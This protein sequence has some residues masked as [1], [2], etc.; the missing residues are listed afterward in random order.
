[1]LAV[2]AGMASWLYVIGPQARLTSPVLMKIA[3][4][5]YPMMDLALFV[6]ALRLIF[7]AGRGRARSSC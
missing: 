7:G 2:V 6:V 4:L 1:M 3:S 5:G